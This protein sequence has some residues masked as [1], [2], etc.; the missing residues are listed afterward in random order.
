MKKRLV[1]V[2]IFALGGLFLLYLGII[3]GYGKAIAFFSSGVSLLVISCLSW[4]V[5]SPKQLINGVRDFWRAL[6]MTPEERRQ[7]AAFK[8]LVTQQNIEPKRFLR[9][10]ID[11]IN[12]NPKAYLKKPQDYLEISLLIHSGLITDF[13]LDRLLG[14]LSI[15]GSGPAEQFE[16]SD[17]LIIQKT[18]Q[19]TKWENIVV[20]LSKEIQEYLCCRRDQEDHVNVHVCLSGYRNSKVVLKLETFMKNLQVPKLPS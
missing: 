9:L 7:F 20:R 3:S 6:R 4:I 10:F 2:V 19:D 14:T 8:E 15:D 12:F 18:G 16:V 13:Q 17:N 1:L 11:D 5:P